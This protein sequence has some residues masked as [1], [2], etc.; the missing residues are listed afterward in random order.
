MNPWRKLGMNTRRRSFSIARPKN[1]HAI[2]KVPPSTPLHALILDDEKSYVDL[3]SVV[4]RDFLKCPVA[5]FT[6]AEK[7]LAALP[8]LNLGIIVTDFYMPGMDG[9]TFLRLATQIKPDVPCVMITGHSEALAAMDCSDI[10]QLQTVLAKPF[11]GRVLAETISKYW[12]DA[13]K[14]R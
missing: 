11:G 10:S 9:I 7:A 13:G 8:N 14:L 2:F 6:S 5:T 1:S 4:L 3:M 12:P